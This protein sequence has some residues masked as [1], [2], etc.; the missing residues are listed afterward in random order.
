MNRSDAQ[1][2]NDLAHARHLLAVVDLSIAI[3]LRQLADAQPGYPTGGDGTRTS[4]TISDRTG[5][6]ATGGAAHD[7]ARR[8]R[9]NLA[10][11]AHRI[12]DDMNDLHRIVQAW[13]PP[14]HKWRHHLATETDHVPDLGCVSC[15][16]T[17]TYEPRRSE[18]GDLCR[19]CQD[20]ARLLGKRL[21]PIELVERHHQGKR[22]TDADLRRF[23]GKP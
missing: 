3:A 12:A 2:R 10:D 11:L 21:P 9:D 13:R 6:L 23:G 15:R 7:P 4:G 16:R 22:I 14:T 17:G 5:H 19:W 18:G 20:I 8:A 1:I